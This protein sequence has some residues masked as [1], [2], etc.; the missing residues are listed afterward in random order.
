M[1]GYSPIQGPII[2][3]SIGFSSIGSG[4]SGGYPGL[5]YLHDFTDQVSGIDATITGDEVL[6][7]QTMVFSSV[8]IPVESREARDTTAPDDSSA[9]VSNI[10]LSKF[11]WSGFT[12]NI[13]P[14][15]LL[16]YS[17]RYYDSGWIDVDLDTIFSTLADNLSLTPGDYLT[18]ITC[19]DMDSNQVI[20]SDTVTAEAWFVV[21]ASGNFAVDAS[22][23]LAVG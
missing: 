6:S 11:T 15:A 8:A 10:G 20:F 9:T 19:Q 3:G 22:G 14:D 23:N 1:I 4:G 12:D 16:R 18:E 2:L 7:R 13:T 5:F 17:F 21:D